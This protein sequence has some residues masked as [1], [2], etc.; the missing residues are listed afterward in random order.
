MN[1]SSKSTQDLISS[2]E[3]Q[4][5]KSEIP[6]ISVGDTVRIGILIQEGNKQRTQ[7]SEGVVICKKNSGLN[8]TVTL[9]KVLQGIGVE[10]VY[11]LHSP[12]IQKIS[13][14][15]R[16]KVR[17]S[18]LYYLRSLSGKATRLKQRFD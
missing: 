9:R 12:R 15:R 11:L 16:S 3:S 1:F 18:K 7:F 14:L 2:I 5:L 6:I 13:I 4:H 10:K 8:T 17:R